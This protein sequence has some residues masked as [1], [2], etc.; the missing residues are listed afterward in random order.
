MKK[1]TILL[2]AL[3]A[4]CAFGSCSKNEDHVIKQQKAQVWATSSTEKVLQNRTDLYPESVRTEKISVFAARGEYESAQ[5]IITGGSS[6][7][8][9]EISANDLT[10]GS[11]TFSK[12]N[13]SLYHEKYAEVAK[14]TK[15]RPHPRAFIRTR[16]YPT[17]RL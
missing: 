4:A 8:T 11:E 6:E 2:A 12:D 9:Y 17:K 3:L 14:I 13:I 7:V 5:V 10:G 16:L 15:T 1:Q